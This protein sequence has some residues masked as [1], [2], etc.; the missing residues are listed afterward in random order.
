MK[1]ADVQKGFN[2]DSHHSED[3][4]QSLSPFE[5][6]LC[7][8]LYRIEIT[9]KRGR[10]VPVLL[11]K[12]MKEAVDLIMSKRQDAGVTEKNEFVFG[13]ANSG[14]IGHIRGN[15]VLRKLVLQVDL[16]YPE[17]IKSTKLRKHIATMTKLVNLKDNEL[18]VVPNFLATT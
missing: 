4:L 1:L 12:N 5:R 8:S 2:N 18:D 6:Q 11:T 13:R 3:V 10:T 17:T 16:R 14:L 7:Q 15:D 9:G